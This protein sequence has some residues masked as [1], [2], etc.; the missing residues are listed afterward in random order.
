[1]IIIVTWHRNIFQ[2]SFFLLT[3]RSTRSNAVTLS[4]LICVCVRS[5]VAPTDWAGVYCVCSCISISMSIFIHF[6]SNSE[7][8]GSLQFIVQQR[9]NKRKRVEVDRL[10]ASQ[11]YGTLYCRTLYSWGDEAG[12]HSVRDSYDACKDFFFRSNSMELGGDGA[13]LFATEW[14]RVCVCVR[15]CVWKC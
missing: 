2:E 5:R 6:I 7:R 10:A 13:L 4:V 8:S 1:M 12:T 11:L 3:N 15:V 14:A 9:A